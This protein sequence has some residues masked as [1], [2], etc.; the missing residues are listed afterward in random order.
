MRYNQ[1]DALKKVVAYYKRKHKNVKN[2]FLVMISNFYHF[3]NR[4]LNLQ[5][6]MTLLK[7]H[8]YLK[9]IRKTCHVLGQ[10]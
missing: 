3:I 9:M 2:E 4:T 7:I 6:I 8:I 5:G 1:H 10:L